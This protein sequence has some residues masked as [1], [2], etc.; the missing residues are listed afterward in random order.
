M[1]LSHVRL[2]VTPWTLACQAPPSM[3]FSRQEYWRGLPFPSPGDLP[4][5][6]SEP[7]SPSF[8]ADSLPSEPAGKLKINYPRE[9]LLNISKRVEP[10]VF[11][12]GAIP[13]LVPPHSES[14]WPAASSFVDNKESTAQGAPLK[15]QHTGEE[16]RWRKSRTG[17]TL[18][19]PQ[20]HQK[21]I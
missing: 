2:F 5:P 4:D 9:R 21:S 13:I 10:V 16:P 17:R 7:R 18:S 1:L 19:P 8:Q 12:L 6:G 11:Q 20:I 14:W 15:M 3:V